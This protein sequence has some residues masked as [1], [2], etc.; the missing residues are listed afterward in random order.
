MIEHQKHNQFK[1]FTGGTFGSVAKSTEEYFN[2][3]NSH[4]HPKS[5]SIGMVSNSYLLTVGYTVSN[6]APIYNIR[7][8]SEIIGTENVLYNA[9]TLETIL[10]NTTEGREVICH[11]LFVEEGLLRIYTMEVAE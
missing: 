6:D 7:L 4:Y 10:M 3:E 8:Q 9:I 5:M 1:V 11:D 2:N